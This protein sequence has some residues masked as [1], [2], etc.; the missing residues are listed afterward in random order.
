MCGIIAVV[1]N[2]NKFIQ[3]MSNGLKNLQNRG[4]DSVGIC[5]VEN[6]KFLLNKFSST[7]S[8]NAF[9][10]LESCYFQ[11][12]NSTIGIGHTRWA[13]HGQRNN[14]NAHPHISSDNKISLVHNGIIEN[15]IQLKEIVLKEGYTFISETDTEVIV[16][17]LAFCYRKNHDIVKS[18]NEVS[19]L[20]HGSWALAIS[21]IDTPDIIYCTRKDN[22][23]LI[24]THDDY[25]IISSEQ[26]GFNQNIN[27][28]FILYNYYICI[29]EK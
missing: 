4:Y 10:L 12:L 17:L 16:N 11:Y 5:S 20:L 22:P 6:N 9:D 24:G 13:T 2:N 18:I 23:L 21:C 3:M 29:I 15:Y 14:A 27:K 7:D 8:T 19:N 1:S 25:V 28:Y 26:A